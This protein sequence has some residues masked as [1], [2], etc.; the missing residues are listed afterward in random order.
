MAEFKTV[1]GVRMRSACFWWLGDPGIG[2]AKPGD[3]VVV[4]DGRKEWL[5]DLGAG[6]CV[7]SESCSTLNYGTLAVFDK[8]L[9]DSGLGT[10]AGAG[11]DESSISI[12]SSALSNQAG[13]NWKWT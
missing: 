9:C 4:T 1:T 8:V 7:W 5:S 2:S 10:C 11:G 12:Q 3:Q 6:P 13:A